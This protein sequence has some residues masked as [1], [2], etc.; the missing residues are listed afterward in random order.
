MKIPF[1]SAWGIWQFLAEKAGAGCEAPTVN[2]DFSEFTGTVIPAG[3]YCPLYI[4]T[5]LK[6]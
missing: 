4:L 1:N 6:H 5:V 3:C 2:N